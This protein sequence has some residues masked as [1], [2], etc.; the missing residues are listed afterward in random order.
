LNEYELH[1]L[2][3]NDIKT[4]DEILEDKRFLISPNTMWKKR[5]D[6]YLILLLVYISTYFVYA[7]T[8]NSNDSVFEQVIDGLIDF[9]FLIDIFLSFFVVTQNKNGF[10]LTEHS[11]IVK[12]YLKSWF[13]IDVLT[14]IPLDI[15]VVDKSIGPEIA[16]KKI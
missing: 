12:S 2:N 15:F 1:Q 10:Y 16:I 8:F 9:S 11:K 5:W 4:I 7:T 3:N 6:L 14:C 13:F